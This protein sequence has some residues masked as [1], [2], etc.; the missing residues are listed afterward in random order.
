MQIAHAT[1]L[2]RACLQWWWLCNSISTAVRV[3]ESVVF[4][5]YLPP[6]HRRGKN[7]EKEKKMCHVN[8]YLLVCTVV[9]GTSENVL[10]GKSYL[11]L[12]MHLRHI[13]KTKI[14]LQ[15]LHGFDVPFCR[16][17][18]KA[19]YESTRR[20]ETKYANASYNARI[21]Q[22]YMY[23]SSASILICEKV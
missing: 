1:F 20:L 5:S 19:L 3:V 10:R 11:H 17:W 13:T 23:A 9:S 12:Q 21:H 7:R 15:N 22:M 14:C 8:L 4:H 16:F 2:V 18:I 6:H